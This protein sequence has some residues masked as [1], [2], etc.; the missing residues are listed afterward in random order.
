MRARKTR[1]FILTRVNPN[2]RDIERFVL[3]CKEIEAT[4]YGYCVRQVNEGKTMLRGFF[5]L[6]G[7]TAY[8]SQLEAMFPNFLL[9]NMP[10]D[11]DMETLKEYEGF[12]GLI[13]AGEHPFLDIK[14]DLFK[15]EFKR[16]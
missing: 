10:V 1:Y 14:I 3:S 12:P 16:L 15:N 13:V 7:K 6:S 9:W 8:P 11:M 4:Y 2:E 5:V